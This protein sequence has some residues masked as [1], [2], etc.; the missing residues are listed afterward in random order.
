MTFFYGPLHVNVPV[1]VDKQ[2]LIYIISVR[3]QDVLWITCQ[4]WW[5]IGTDGE[6]ES[7]KFTVSV[8]LDDD[9]D[10][11]VDIGLFSN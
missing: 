10:D 11:T 7:R 6:R 3:T 5:M 8:R 2:E 1:L 9:D 4:E